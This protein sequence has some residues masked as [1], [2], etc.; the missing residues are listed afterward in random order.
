MKS[1]YPFADIQLA[2]AAKTLHTI[3]PGVGTCDYKQVE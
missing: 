3:A 1:E 2:S